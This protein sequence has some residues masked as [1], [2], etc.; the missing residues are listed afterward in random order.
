MRGVV[1]K[2]SLALEKP[3]DETIS[4]P[5]QLPTRKGDEVRLKRAR[6]IK[7]SSLVSKFGFG[8]RPAPVPK[9]VQPLSVK[10]A[11]IEHKAHHAQAPTHTSNAHQH[12][13]NPAQ[14]HFNRALAHAHAHE[15][16][17][18]HP[19]KKP[20]RRIAHRLGMSQKV[21]NVGAGA[22][23]AILLLGFFA[24]QNVPNISMRIAASRAGF[25][26]KLPSYKPTGF[27]FGGPIQYAPGQ[28]TVNFQSNSDDRNFHL[29]Q[30]VSSWNSEAL[31]D[32]Y[33]LANSK[34]YQTYQD[35]GR[36]IYIYDGAN[37]T[38]VS[39][40]IWYQIEGESSLTNDQLL[41]VANS[42]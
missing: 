18:H 25:S 24:Y 5:T 36:T 4:E 40:G 7:M 21:F 13:V 20:R 11:P 34:T 29:T 26:A 12:G 9:K 15:Q 41:Q 22:L 28:I 6:E 2:P 33:L 1:S 42:I 31:L 8:G 10:Q 39:G 27:S 38:W 32:N 16:P 30:K 35:K 17:K 37:A 14:A 23:A 19:V 3:I